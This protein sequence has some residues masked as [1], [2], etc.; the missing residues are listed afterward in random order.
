MADAEE[1]HLSGGLGQKRLAGEG[2]MAEP[3]S[4]NH[5]GEA[6]G[7]ALAYL[8][9]LTPRIHWADGPT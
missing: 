9:S 6:P 2:L 1:Q 4:T 8:L 3:V 7:L 5:R